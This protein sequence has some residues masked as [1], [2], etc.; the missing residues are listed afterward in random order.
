[1][2]LLSTG[3]LTDDMAPVSIVGAHGAHF[4]LDDGREVLD[5]SNTGAPLGHRHPKLIEAILRAAETPALNEGWAWPERDEAAQAMLELAFD[6]EADW[7]GAVRFFLSGSEA[8][9]QAL[10]LALALTGRPALATR[11]RAYHGLVGLARDVTVQP[12]WHGGLSSQSGGWRAVPRAVEIRQLAAPRCGIHRD[13]GAG[14]E[15]SCLAGAAETL[16][17]V[18][19]VIIDY[20]QGGIY[21]S[22]RYQE[23]LAAAA[24]EAG[25]LWI[26]D[27]V[28]T[29]LGRQGGWFTFQRAEPRPDMVTLGKGLT[30]G[31][32]PGGAVVVSK[33]LLARLEGQSWR[34]YSTF[35]GHPITVA[36]MT[37]TLRALH[38]E[39]LVERANE[40][41]AFMR[42]TLG[43]IKDRH[44]SVES[45][46]GLGLHWTIEL[47]G[48]D[49]REWYADT[50]ETPLAGR[51]SAAALDGGAMIATSGE[52]TSL[53]LAPPLVA[54]DEELR[55]LLEI[56]DAALDVAD[57]AL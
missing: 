14:D 40:A 43:E 22:P 11:E 25:A 21:P 2:R 49:W 20:S 54:T 23:A 30:G 39:G 41:D 47:Y 3:L 50:A 5:G 18:A 29:G 28:V 8:N 1:V 46:D 52:A 35:R 53:F 45:V 31:V 24:R 6:G 9:D 33:D 56:L 26:A 48:L 16:A 34:S 44:P 12:Q 27:E 17:D 4:V 51:V 13:C 36:A 37:A 32:A 19:A 15:C 42:R 38:E 7:V 10:S 57:Q 55:R